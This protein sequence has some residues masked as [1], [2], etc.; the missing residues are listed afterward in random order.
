MIGDN[1]IGYSSDV[2][3]AIR[4][5]IDIDIPILNLSFGWSGDDIEERYDPALNTIID[6]YPGLVVC[7]AGNENQNNNSLPHFPSNCSADN[8]IAVGASTQNNTKW[9]DSNYGSWTV[10]VF[11]PGENIATTFV[12]GIGSN[13]GTSLAAPFV[14]G[15]AALILSQH[16]SLSGAQLRDIIMDSADTYTAL[17]GKCVTGG[18]VNAYKAV[19]SDLAHTYVA[20]RYTYAKHKC[21]CECG[22]YYYES[23]TWNDAETMCIECETPLPA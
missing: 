20:H 21:E 1:G 10:D 17:S 8:L 13:D 4:Y 18:R 6:A 23:H 22:D 7:C 16:P 5:A 14:S 2:I 12:N 15:I 9:A 3:R 19:T 11:A